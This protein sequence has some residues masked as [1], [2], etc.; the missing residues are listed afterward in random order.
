LHSINHYNNDAVIAGKQIKTPHPPVP[1]N[2]K[3]NGYLENP[4]KWYN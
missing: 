3:F 4:F 1:M 2:S